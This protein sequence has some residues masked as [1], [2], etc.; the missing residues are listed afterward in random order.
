MKWLRV[1]ISIMQLLTQLS[2]SKWHN[3]HH[4]VVV[5]LLWLYATREESSLEEERL[6][7]CGEVVK[8]LS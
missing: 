2:I 4:L 8:K 7:N 3:H 1:G 5:F 6:E